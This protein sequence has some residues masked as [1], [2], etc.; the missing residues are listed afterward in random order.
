KVTLPQ[1]EDSREPASGRR[2]YVN[3]V[4]MTMVEMKPGV[5]F[6]QRDTIIYLT[7]P[8]FA[9]TCEVSL[10]QFRLFMDDPNYPAEKKS[11]WAGA[12]KN[13]SPTE[14]C[15][16]NNVTRQHIIQFCNWLSEREGRGICYTKSGP[17]PDDW[18]CDFT[19]DGY[20]L[21]TESEWDYAHR[22]G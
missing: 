10:K 9:E 21:P 1:I 12:D 3:S 16:V 8:Y 11:R 18:D 6:P 13:T 4:G 20:R 7:R 14:D 15:P 5:L 2:W 17:K 22:A 19:A